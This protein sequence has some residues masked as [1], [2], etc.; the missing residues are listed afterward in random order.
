MTAT[1]LFLQFLREN[2]TLGEYLFFREIISH[3]PG[4]RYF[5]TRPLFKKDFVEGYLSRNNRQLRGFMRRL[6][7]L[8]PN[9]VKRRNSNPRWQMLYD[10]YKDRDD[11]DRYWRKWWLSVMNSK[12][13]G[14]YVMYYSSLWNK[15]LEERVDWEKSNKKACSC[16]KQKEDNQF[17][18]RTKDGTDT[19]LQHSSGRPFVRRQ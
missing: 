15:F 6:F 14:V 18:L 10:R 1:Q 9:L 3:N 5:K 11:L 12:G 8:A 19:R 7:I 2:C 17:V 13:A 16:F 4:N